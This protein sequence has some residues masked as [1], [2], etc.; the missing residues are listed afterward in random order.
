MRDRGV[1]YFSRGE[2]VLWLCSVLAV[3]ASFCIFDRE[4]YLTLAASLVG[5]TSLIFIAKG[6]PT[7]QVLMIIFSLM[8]GAV[9]YSFA[10]Y[11]EMI[12]YVGMTMPMAAAA[13]ISWI[14]NPYN[15][16]KSEVRV[17]RISLREWE[18]I[19]ALTAGV[20]VIFYFILK[21]LG[22]SNIITST[23]SVSTS[24]IAVYLTFRRSPYYAAG[25]A[26]N[27]AVLIVLWCLAAK[28]DISYISVIVCFAAFLVNDL[29]GLISWKKMERRQTEYLTEGAYEKD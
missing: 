14:R 2:A 20:T 21:Y 8:Y 29:Y 22:T 19:P 10:Y 4:N 11:G 26:A 3:T 23:L 13:L 1:K 12:T 18:L 25:Y 15:G 27:D 24:F 6:N 5:V 7:G 17:N 16:Q 9:S 28:E